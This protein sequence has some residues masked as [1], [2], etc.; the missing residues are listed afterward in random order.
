[1]GNGGHGGVKFGRA[2]CYCVYVVRYNVDIM[3]I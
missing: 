1:M 2:L 3:L